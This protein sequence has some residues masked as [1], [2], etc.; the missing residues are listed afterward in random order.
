[1]PRKEL[2]E[3]EKVAEPELFE[4]I[5]SYDNVPL[6]KFAGKIYEEIDGELVTFDPEDILKRDICISDT[7]FRDG[8]Q[9]RPPYTVDQIEALYNLLARLDGQ[10]GLIRHSEFFL[11]SEKDREAVEKCLA[12]GH[13][14]PKV[15]GWIR[16]D[17]GDFELVRKM[18]LTETGILTSCSDYHIF[19]K[20]RKN[21][22][23]IL[24]HYLGVVKTA[25]DAG[26]RPRCHLEDVTRAD[27]D[28]FVIPFLQRVMRLG[29]EVPEELTPK[30]RLCDTMG[31]GITYPGAALPRSIPKLI[32]KV[33]HEAGVPSDRLEWH[34]H[35]DFHKVHINAVTSWLYGC[36]VV[37]T[38]LMGFGE[39]TGNPPLEAA[40]FEY[41]ALTGKSEGIDTTVITEIAE[42][43]Q[44]VVQAA[45]P[46]N[47]PFVGR[48]FN[49][50][51][52][53]I[54]A[55]GLAR[56]ERIYNIFNT[57]KLLG[58]PARVAITDKSGVDG[59]C[60]WVNNFL[61]LEGK[62][63]LSKTKVHKIARWV[64]DQ[65]DV[66]HRTTAISERELEELVK[67]HLPEYYEAREKRA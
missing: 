16:A 28:G 34:G 44:E 64:V 45:I 31:F 40:V 59:V 43:L 19:Y 41:M 24:D 27:I 17:E 50:T 18:G 63:R 3:L 61:G 51:R 12:L 48:E 39:R 65:Y 5:F 20:L 42:Y 8:Q 25:L 66:H 62:D 30:V 32:Y 29:E 56:D 52:A 57:Q 54:H 23:Q 60:L 21:R 10:T 53:G 22:Q 37:N 26:V 49:L 6:I 67:Q 47:Y 38:T 4:D 35:N 15:T 33:I 55:D 14:Y 1:M 58:I 2:K 46:A 36:D 9:A 7:T 11:Y 13:K